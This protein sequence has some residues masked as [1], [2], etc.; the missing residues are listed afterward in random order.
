MSSA[1]GC[2]W[3]SLVPSTRAGCRS[4]IHGASS[5]LEALRHPLGD[6]LAQDRRVILIDRPGHGWS[7]RDRLSHSTPAMQAQMIDEALGKLSVDR[8]II[9]GHSWAGALA[10]AFALNHAQRV[11]GLVMLSPV[12]HRWV[13]GIPWHHNL[14]A[15]P[16]IGP[17][18][19]YTFALPTGMLMID[20]GARG[21]FLPQT[22]PDNYVR[23]TSL[24]LLLRPREFL[25]NAWDMVSLK[26]AVTEQMPRYSEIK[27]PTVVI[28]GDADTTVYLDVHAR[29]FVQAVPHASLIVVPG[30]GHVIQNAAAETIIAAIETVM[31][32]VAAAAAR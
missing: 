3:S 32:P 19:A 30:V 4:V 11:A 25:A 16:I 10:A 29:Q 23:D 31:P 20:K 24:K 1:A 22:I 5:N 27:A 7:T 2:M 13:G 17:L 6:L 26:D 15:I 28:H 14:G 8:A 9:V 21:A 12:T 18:F